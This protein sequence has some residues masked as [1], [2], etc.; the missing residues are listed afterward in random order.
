MAEAICAKCYGFPRM[1]L[2]FL[3]HNVARHH[4]NFLAIGFRVNGEKKI[5]GA[6]LSVRTL[7]F[8]IGAILGAIGLFLPD[9]MAAE[10]GQPHEGK[11]G[12]KGHA[13]LC[14]RPFCGIVLY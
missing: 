11:K 7:S 8:S 4:K 9:N 14:G 3:P 13:T 6:I 12:K 1:H 5:C 10:R 2:P